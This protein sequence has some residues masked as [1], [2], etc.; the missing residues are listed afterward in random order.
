M[1]KQSQEFVH[2]IDGTVIGNPA[3]R[4]VDMLPGGQ[5][6]LFQIVNADGLGRYKVYM[7]WVGSGSVSLVTST[8]TTAVNAQNG[9]GW[10]GSL[11]SGQYQF[12]VS[13]TVTAAHCGI[14]RVN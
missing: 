2:S 12:K 6:E 1:A 3:Y 8:G 4:N 7:G 5:T 10:Q 14:E 13:G 11:A 9:G